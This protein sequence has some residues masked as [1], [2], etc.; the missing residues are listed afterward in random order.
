MVD[1]SEYA[2]VLLRMLNHCIKVCSTLQPVMFGDV[3]FE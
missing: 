1:F 2:A 3:S